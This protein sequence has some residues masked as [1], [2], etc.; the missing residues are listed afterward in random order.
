MAF[1]ISKTHARIYSQ[2]KYNHTYFYVTA[3]LRIIKQKVFEH[4]MFT[5][6]QYEKTH[7]FLLVDIA[8]CF[9]PRHGIHRVRM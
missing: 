5:R 9:F 6:C 2:G 3:T 4:Q 1:H 8:R 7:R